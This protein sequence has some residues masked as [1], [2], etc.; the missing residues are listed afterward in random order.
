MTGWGATRIPIILWESWPLGPLRQSRIGQSCWCERSGTERL[1]G[2]KGEKR[3]SG[4]KDARRS[5]SQVFWEW[6]GW[7]HNFWNEAKSLNWMRWTWGCRSL[8]VLP[9]L[10]LL[11]HLPLSFS[12]SYRSTKHSH[13]PLQL[14]LMALVI[15]KLFPVC[16]RRE[17][18]L[19]DCKWKR[20]V[21]ASGAFTPHYSSYRVGNECP[22]CSPQPLCRHSIP[23]LLPKKE[24]FFF[25]LHIFKVRLWSGLVSFVGGD[26]VPTCKRQQGSG[27]SLSCGQIFPATALSD[28]HIV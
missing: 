2:L 5:T 25:Y 22:T 1:G 14:G 20:H 6:L 3:I 9:T 16:E 8:L 13:L 11:V 4:H 18:S 24:N 12:H 10:P 19:P 15:S 27:A 23:R 21:F 17:G 28:W 7:P 26:S